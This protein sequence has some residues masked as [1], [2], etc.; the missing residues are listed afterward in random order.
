MKD[1]YHDNFVPFFRPQVL[2]F[3][4]GERRQEF[5]KKLKEVK[6]ELSQCFNGV[7]ST[8]TGKDEDLRK[9]SSKLK[10]KMNAVLLYVGIV[11]LLYYFEFQWEH[12]S[13]RFC[14][15]TGIYS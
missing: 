3:G 7:F 5:L 14:S 10:E 15:F 1:L 12:F 9:N 6:N 11:K 2:L 8:A 13:V 4:F